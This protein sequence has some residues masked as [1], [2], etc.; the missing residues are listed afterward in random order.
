MS[1]L[2]HL[3]VRLAPDGPFGSGRM[4]FTRD[5][6][7]CMSLPSDSRRFEPSSRALKGIADL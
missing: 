2:Q 5:P 3:Q 6:R 1:R 7:K 4:G